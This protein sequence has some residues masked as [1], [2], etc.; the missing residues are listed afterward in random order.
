[1]TWIEFYIYSVIANIVLCIPFLMFANSDR[2]GENLKEGLRDITIKDIGICLGMGI[3]PLF[4]FFTACIEVFVVVTY[5]II[6]F[7]IKL[8]DKDFWDVH[9]FVKKKKV[10]KI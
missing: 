10:K 4:N 2:Y 8:F 6:G 3:V 1:M 7:F 5:P 9:P